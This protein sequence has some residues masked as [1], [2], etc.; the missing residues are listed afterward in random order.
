MMAFER[1]VCEIYY[2]LGV[3]ESY[4]ERRIVL[5]YNHLEFE[6]RADAERFLAENGYTREEAGGFS[7]KKHEAYQDAWITRNLRE[8]KE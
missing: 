1:V 3:Y 8:I 4:S 2:K 7:W 5:D 6:T